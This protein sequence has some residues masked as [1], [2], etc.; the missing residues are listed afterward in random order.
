MSSIY[1]PPQTVP[2]GSVPASSDL[3]MANHDILRLATVN[4]TGTSV[5]ASGIDKA[6]GLHVQP[7]A[8]RMIT[9]P[10]LGA[11]YF[12][13]SSA[14]VGNAPVWQ[15][16]GGF[17]QNGLTLSK[18]LNAN[19]Q[20]IHGFSALLGGGGF[21]K[22]SSGIGADGR[23]THDAAYL[24]SL[25]ST[26][27]ADKVLIQ[28][29]SEGAGNMP[30]WVDTLLE[31]T[32]TQ[33]LHGRAQIPRVDGQYGLGYATY[34]WRDVQ[35]KNH[36]QLFSDGQ[37]AVL[38]LS[39]PVTST[40]GARLGALDVNGSSEIF[41]LNE[42]GEFSQV[43]GSPWRVIPIHE[44]FTNGDGSFSCTGTRAAGYNAALDSPGALRFSLSNE[45]NNFFAASSDYIWTPNLTLA[46]AS[47]DVT[48]RFI[49]PSNIQSVDSFECYAGFMSHNTSSNLQSVSNFCGLH[50][51]AA[52]IGG[53]VHLTPKCLEGNS[54]TSSASI[55]I[56]PGD[57]VKVRVVNY[58]TDFVSIT[59]GI[60]SS[61]LSELA[62]IA[63]NV[64]TLKV[65]PYFGAIRSDAG[66]TNPLNFYLDAVHGQI[67]LNQSR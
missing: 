64:P 51:V 20:L 8:V 25:V 5:Y 19:S 60:N 41:T 38:P 61:S 52:A 49:L 3:D 45:S 27:G 65:A 37:F 56:Q 48:F 21:G 13:G 36:V 7:Y 30:V 34:R 17:Y 62:V 63:T 59:Y 43:S 24:F 31:L 10:V 44:E 9:N 14:G 58:G 40:H 1:N 46:Q 54:Q 12:Q 53:Q 15:D 39:G 66:G 11:I 33:A 2:L 16:A 26:D 67:T 4:S 35:V 6:T 22:L 55:M 28:K 18:A 42:S 50:L 47:M 57:I 29:S 23:H 32:D